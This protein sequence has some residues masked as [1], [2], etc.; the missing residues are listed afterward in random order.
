MNLNFDLARLSDNKVDTRNFTGEVN[1]TVYTTFYGIKPY[2]RV[3]LGWT[4]ER[5]QAKAFQ[6]LTYHAGVGAEANV[7]KNLSVGGE[8]YLKDVQK[9]R[10]TYSKAQASPPTIP[11]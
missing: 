10:D 9:A 5:D 8:F 1:S 11:G 2:A 7:F 6:A 4:W 3:G